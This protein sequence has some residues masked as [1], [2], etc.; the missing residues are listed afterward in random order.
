[1]TNHSGRE[2]ASILPSASHAPAFGRRFGT[3]IMVKA[4]MAKA[5]A[6]SCMLN[7]TKTPQLVSKRHKAPHPAAI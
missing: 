5:A 4:P 3:N 6:G 2:T 1:M 7:G